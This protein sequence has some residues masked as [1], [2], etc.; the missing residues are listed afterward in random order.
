MASATHR[1]DDPRS[2]ILIFLHIPKAAGMSVRQVIV[3]QYGPDRVCI[4]QPQEG[5]MLRQQWEYLRAGSKAPTARPGFDPNGVPRRELANLSPDVLSRTHVV[6]GHL[7]FGLHDALPRPA[8]YMTV[9]RDPV[10]RVL[11]LYFYR[12]RRQGLTGSLEDYLDARRDF[13]IDNGQTRYLC[14]RLEGEDVRFTPCTPAML[15]MAKRHL[16]DRFSVV[17]VSE[18]FDQS[19]LLMARTYGWHLPLYERHNVNR[20]RPRGLRVPQRVRDRIAE[21]NRFDLELHTF[22]RDLLEARL[23]DEDIGSAAVRG[24]QRAN[25][26]HR[27]PVLR[28]LYPVTRPLLRV[29]RSVNRG[30]RRSRTVGP[31]PR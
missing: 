12:K 6:M 29:A 9:L 26:L 21:Q 31:G 27:N 23:A 11:S 22:A 17:G 4:P 19:L 30:A 16:R 18:H 7:W 24:F 8:A 28:A 14:G 1:A 20:L 15:D 2:P 5:P 13:E 10:E 3:R 25:L